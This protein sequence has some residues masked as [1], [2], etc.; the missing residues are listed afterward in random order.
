MQA[1]TTVTDMTV[2][3]SS[4]TSCFLLDQ[5]FTE[6]CV[7][8]SRLASTCTT[9]SITDRELLTRVFDSNSPSIAWRM[10]ND[11][12]LPKTLVKK[13]KWERQFNHLI[14]EKKE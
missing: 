4:V 6:I 14:M 13:A 9:E 12:F 7:K 10:L 3:D 5:G 2:G 11:W 1:L 8:R